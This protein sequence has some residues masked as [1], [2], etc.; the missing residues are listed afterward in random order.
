MK[1]L[2][3][4]LYA[5]IGAANIIGHALGIDDMV[6]FSKPMLM[7]ALI[8]L[9][10]RHANGN[11]PLKTIML[12]VALVFSWLGDM[13]LMQEGELYFMLG[14]G[15]FLLAQITYMYIF[16]KASFEK[17][18]FRLMP[19]L[20]ILT[21]TIFLLAYLVPALPGNLQIPVVVYALCLTG[22]ACMARL[23]FGLTSNQ[24]YQWVVMGSLLFVVSDSAIAIDKFY[25]PIPYDDVVIMSTYI[26]AQLLI[27]LG[28][29]RHPD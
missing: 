15:G 20:P 8:W 3:L 19:L 1:N 10:Y 12:V 17:P 23:R 21:Y 25:R 9:V 27:V 13:A 24:S 29:L 16:L 2:P 14:L 11:V 7:P 5:I 6:K 26:G 28:I 18:E 4:L 22:M